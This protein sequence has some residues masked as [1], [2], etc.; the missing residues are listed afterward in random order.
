MSRQRRSR[1]PLKADGNYMSDF[2]IEMYQMDT[3]SS[4][5]A[6]RNTLAR[7][8]RDKLITRPLSDRIRPRRAW[9]SED[10]QR[11]GHRG[12]SAADGDARPA[13]IPRDP[14]HPAEAE[15]ARSNRAGRMAQPSVRFRGSEFRKAEH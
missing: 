15:A 8:S 13:Q 6:G 7:G 2:E 10:R 11:K 9:S 3:G 5:M 14:L 12:V 4:F 1:R